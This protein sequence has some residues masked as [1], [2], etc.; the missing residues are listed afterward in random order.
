MA[1]QQVCGQVTDR[2]P[3]VPK[4]VADVWNRFLVVREK[5]K[6]T[7]RFI[8]TWNGDA[9]YLSITDSLGGQHNKLRTFTGDRG[10]GELH[11]RIKRGGQIVRGTAK[12][13]DA[14]FDDIELI[15]G[16]V[17]EA[18]SLTEELEDVATT[19]GPAFVRTATFRV[20]LKPED[21]ELD[22][23]NR[24]D[25]MKILDELAER[26]RQE[27][28]V[29]A[30]PSKKSNILAAPTSFVG[31]GDDIKF[32]QE[33]LTKP[34]D[35]R[36]SPVVSIWGAPG[37]GKTRLASEVCLKLESHFSG[38]VR[39]IDLTHATSVED[40]CVEIARV[41]NMSLPK[42]QELGVRAIGEFLAKCKEPT[43]L[44][45]DNFDHALDFISNTVGH[46]RK[47]ASRH[48]FLLTSREQPS[49]DGVQAYEL[50]PLEYPDIDEANRA[51]SSISSMDGVQLFVQLAVYRNG[52]FTLSESNAPHVAGIVALLE[53][54]PLALELAAARLVST[55]VST[56]Y[57][58][59]RES[60][61]ENLRQRKADEERPD[62]HRTM[63]AAIEWSF[64]LLEDHE[65]TALVEFSIFCGGCFYDA[66]EAVLTS[67][68]EDGH[69]CSD[70]IEALHQMGFL[71]KLPAPTD[72]PS[73]NVRYALFEVIREFAEGQTGSSAAHEGPG[74]DRH[75]NEVRQ[76]H[77]AHLVNRLGME[78]MLLHSSKPHSE[79]TPRLRIEWHNVKYLVDEAQGD[80]TSF[81]PRSKAAEL[82][83]LYLDV[84]KAL[85]TW[86]DIL[87]TAARAIEGSRLCGDGET[88]ATL[89]LRFADC[90]GVLG[91][92]ER[93]A[94]L[95]EEL[96][97]IIATHPQATPCLRARIWTSAALSH[98]KG[99]S[100][101]RATRILLRCLHAL[102]RDCGSTVSFAFMLRAAHRLR[103][104]G[105]YGAAIFELLDKFD[106]EQRS[107]PAEEQLASAS[108]RLDASLIRA[109]ALLDAG[110]L[111]DA[112]KLLFK[113]HDAATS[114]RMDHKVT[115]TKLL[116]AKVHTR[117][118][119]FPDAEMALDHVEQ[120][121]D[122]N[123]AP[124]MHLELLG[125]RVEIAFRRRQLEEAL[126]AS[127]LALSV[128]REL[129]SDHAV[130][131][132]ASRAGGLLILCGNPKGI[133]L[134]RWAHQKFL[135]NAAIANFTTTVSSLGFAAF[136]ANL[137]DVAVE[138]F[139]ALHRDMEALGLPPAENIGVGYARMLTNNPELG[140]R[141]L[142]AAF[143]QLVVAFGG[144]DATPLITALDA[145]LQL[146]GFK[147][148][149]S[150]YFL[151]LGGIEAG[152]FRPLNAQQAREYFVQDISECHA[153]E[154]L[155]LL[156]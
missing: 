75:I 4:S 127:L 54:I 105:D 78:S 148:V 114:L 141:H 113:A 71:R 5:H 52:K 8:Y 147:G 144:D 41:F 61:L 53:G 112:E 3:K 116:L 107:L 130:A 84:I 91:F 30:S 128:A 23:G 79:L 39:L 123:Y 106:E 100:V 138:L 76:R 65:K 2:F 67:K 59:L 49:L 142:V 60:L 44:L 134:T 77:L 47:I 20:H 36:L 93:A 89:T 146:F 90:L 31:R 51:T 27:Q 26:L 37:L 87:T 115:D 34:N 1:V 28:I 82:M 81:G 73:E 104:S 154:L 62:H 9:A 156:D 50:S 145:E 149:A 83:L 109:E 103:A 69:R 102:T 136:A 57:G 101:E 17:F 96:R 118:D 45:L 88:C 99:A 152:Q 139:D 124:M 117:L 38:G 125:A 7:G 143:R 15:R 40:I 6:K 135:D 22:T 122:K 121:L 18:Q 95:Y 153:E 42:E 70:L 92:I 80:Q 97:R 86:R 68:D 126:E 32:I 55:A 29:Q 16:R 14:V 108:L 140:Y 74:S 13:D 24:F 85:P 58:H 12:C 94:S 110:R 131:V 56:L 111:Q 133:L 11:Y 43:L 132:E 19:A 35:K 72:I 64:S 63:R 21:I 119:R 10:K 120:F 151:K 33:A 25:P 150:R 46:W 98:I 129:Q 66:A 155:S 137:P 48:A